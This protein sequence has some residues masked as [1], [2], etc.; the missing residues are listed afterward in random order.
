MQFPPNQAPTLADALA[1][2]VIGHT[3]DTRTAS[4]AGAFEDADGDPLAISAASSN[5]AVA[6][7]S[8]SSDG[9]SLS[10]NA[11]GRGTAAITVTAVDGRGGSVSDTFT[12]RVKSAPYL[13]VSLADLSGL[14][15]DSS[16]AVSLSA[17]FADHDG[18]PLTLTASSSN[19]AVAR[20]SLSSDG[21]SLS[22]T[23]LAEG[24]ATITVTARDSDD[25]RVSDSFT[26]S[27]VPA[28]PPD[29]TPSVEL[30]EIVAR[31][32]FN[33]NGSIEV[34]EYHRAVNDYSAKRITSSELRQVVLAYLK[35]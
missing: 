16:Q 4:L 9:S 23:G 33:R 30:P 2:V 31:Y 5:S 24:T 15:T 17:T 21:S 1:D 27:V 10:L 32:D 34:S 6:T 18:D 29:R 28:R 22:L 26:V 19:T 11:R 35:H 8:V 25:N 7:A 3:C 13:A 14:E 20:V 12:V